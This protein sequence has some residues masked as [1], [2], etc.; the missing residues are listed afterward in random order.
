MKALIF[1]LLIV[2]ASPTQ[3]IEAMCDT[4]EN[5]GCVEDCLS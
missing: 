2:F 3:D 5:C 1:A 4:D